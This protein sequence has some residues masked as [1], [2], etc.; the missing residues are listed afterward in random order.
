MPNDDAQW[1]ETRKHQVTEISR[2]TRIPPHK[3]ADLEHA[4]FTNIE[5]QGQEYVTDALM[6]WIV[7]WESAIGMQLLGTDWIGLGG[8]Y[9]VKF[10]VNALQRGDFET[11]TKGYA[12]A[13][14]WGWL[15]ANDIRRLEDMN[16]IPGGDDYLIPLNMTTV[17][18]DGS[19]TTTT[20]TP[21]EPAGNGTKPDAVPV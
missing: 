18:P 16:P 4:T 13:R 9:Y 21:R 1:L 3:L 11:R 19:I 5:H 2:W 7:R 10:N 8:D 17:N 20:M 14:Q 12:T 15:S 6:G